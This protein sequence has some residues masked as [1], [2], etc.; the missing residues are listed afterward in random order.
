MSPTPSPSGYGRELHAVYLNSV[1]VCSYI[2]KYFYFILYYFLSFN[3]A[4]DDILLQG[5]QGIPVPWR[6]LTARTLLVEDI[7]S[8]LLWWGSFFK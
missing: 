7:L 2:S 1:C 6:S 4:Y 5:K 3:S 8:Q